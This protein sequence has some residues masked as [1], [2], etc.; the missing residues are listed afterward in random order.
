[1]NK[2]RLRE[3]SP[4]IAG[5]LF[6]LYAVS[7]IV[8]KILFGYGYRIES[9]TIIIIRAGLYLLVGIM[10]LMKKKNFVLPVCFGILSLYSLYLFVWHFVVM[11]SYGGNF[12]TYYV[13]LTLCNLLAFISHL[14][15]AVILLPPRTGSSGIAKNFWFAPAFINGLSV[16]VNLYTVGSI[17]SV[18]A[19]LILNVPCILA[20]AFAGLSTVPN[21][22]H[23]QK[24]VQQTPTYYPPVSN[25]GNYG[26][27]NTM[28]NNYQ[29]YTASIDSGDKTNEIRNYK[30]LMDDGIITAEE[31]EA[32]K[33]QLLGL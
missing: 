25:T 15:M 26:T 10:F 11:V 24:P 28:S 31:F 3:L 9:H 23:Q 7:H 20:W 4:T 29:N 14:L 5:V 32:K 16:M 18:I 13:L 27:A 12:H 8:Q 6:I 30:K 21:E 33:K 22:A 2:A 17:I 1:M 19:F